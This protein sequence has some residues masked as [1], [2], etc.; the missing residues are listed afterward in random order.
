MCV[1]FMN[2]SA[3]SLGFRGGESTGSIGIISSKQN[4]P[5]GCYTTDVFPADVIKDVV[6]F[7][8]SKRE[9]KANSTCKTIAEL[10]VT[11]GILIGGLAYAH[12]AGWIT[13]MGDG[14]L[15]D[16]LTKA[17]KTSYEW[18]AKSKDAA[19]DVYNKVKNYF[20]KKA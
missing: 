10:A 6:N 11:A 14:K 7:K 15:K 5:I 1:S 18:C 20:T 13:K 3:G 16:I 4:S 8:G 12:K 17:S 9:E 2:E 19:V